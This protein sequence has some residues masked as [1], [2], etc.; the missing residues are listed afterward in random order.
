MTLAAPCAELRGPSPCPFSTEVIE[1]RANWS[2]L[3][4]GGEVEREVD[5]KSEFVHFDQEVEL[6]QFT[7]ELRRPWGHQ[8]PVLNSREPRLG[9]IAKVR[10]SDATS[11]TIGLPSAS[12]A[13]NSFGS[14]MPA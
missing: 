1:N 11:R 5:G 9:Q 14:E 13:L 3:R 2:S 7:S 4:L 6:K 12:L 10:R 8:L